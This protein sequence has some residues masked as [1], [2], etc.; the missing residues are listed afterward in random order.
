MDQLVAKITNLS[1]EIFGIFIPGFILLLFLVWW[2]WCVG[3][4]ASLLSVGY[5]PSLA[6]NGVSKGY[7]LIPNEIKL[8]FVVYLA[9]IAYFLG[10][11]INWIGRIGK[12]KE[13]DSSNSK[14]KT[15]EDMINCMRFSIPKPRSSYNQNLETM[16]QRGCRFLELPIDSRNWLSFYPVA[17]SRVVQDLTVSLVSTYQNKYTLHR[18][19]TVASVLLFWLCFFLS[20]FSLTIR[21]EDFESSPHWLPLAFTMIMSVFAVWGFSESYRFHWQNFG[22]S[23]ITE[24]Y[25]LSGRPVSEH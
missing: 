17:K 21:L 22:N 9:V 25:M 7:T 14:K 12:A 18:S 19:L 2:W 4:Q 24:I 23:L 20:I 8:G 15:L 13:S 10:N 16:L 6:V 11:L 1:Y 3:E 5:I